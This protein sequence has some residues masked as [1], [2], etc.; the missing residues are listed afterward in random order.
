MKAVILTA[1]EGKRLRPI[2]TSRP[3]PMIPIIGKPLL[4][5]TV[6][7]LREAGID[8]LILIVGYKEETIRNHFDKFSK[9]FNLKIEYVTQKEFLGTAH[10]LSQVKHTI[11][12]ES[13]LI[14]NGDIFVD[15]GIFKQIVQEYEKHSSEGYIALFKVN[16]PENFGVISLNS[17]GFVEKITEK[18]SP[19][20]KLG[21]LAN[22]GIYIFNTLIFKAIEKTKKSIRNEYEITDSIGIL[23]KEFGV[24]I[25]GFLIEGYWNDIGLPW[26]IF[27]ANHYILNKLESTNLGILEEN[28]KISGNV[29]IGKNSLIKSGSYLQGPC[30]IGDN[31]RIGPNAYIRPYSS[32]NDGCYIGMSEINNSIILSNSTISSSNFVGDSIICENVNL[33]AGTKISNLPFD[34]KTVKMNINGVKIDSGLRKLGAIIGPKSQTGIN[35]RIMSGKIIGNNSIIGAHT[36]VNENVPPNIVYYQESG[37]EILKKPNPS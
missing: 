18:P 37:G 15:T 4:E 7:G 31:C 35:T 17:N 16:N 32:I 1:G 12:D 25:K 22:A 30:Y 21:N 19:R 11:R 5:H 26:Q 36:I 9:E 29:H 20:L 3:K 14:L 33:G 27:E 6:I 13:F 8:H 2:T 10:A 28:V 24:K 34:N 23:I